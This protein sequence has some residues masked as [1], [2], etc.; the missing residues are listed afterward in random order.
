MRKSQLQIFLLFLLLGSTQYFKAYGETGKKNMMTTKPGWYHGICDS[1]TVEFFKQAADKRPNKTVNISDSAK[2]SQI[3]SLLN[4]IPVSGDE[5]IK[6]GP[7]ARYF[8]LI[9][10]CE[11]STR[12]VEFFEDRIKTPSTG[13]LPKGN[14]DE[15]TLVQLL[16]KAE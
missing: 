2:V 11:G 13:F 7:T 4:K 14:A 3:T 15:N 12:V 16:K 1:A 6:M 8:K 10:N 9:L 5:M